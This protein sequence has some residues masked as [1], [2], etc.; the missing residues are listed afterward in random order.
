MQTD[1]IAGE[2]T[3]IWDPCDG[4]V[5]KSFVLTNHPSPDDATKQKLTAEL[6]VA[7][8]RFREIEGDIAP[9]KAAEI[10]AG[11]GFAEERQKLPTQ[12]LSGGWRARV[13]LARALFAEPDVGVDVCLRT[14]RIVFVLEDQGHGVS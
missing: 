3:T 13:A 14:N 9:H 7:Q 12:R 6:V 10:L 2:E 1:Q 5:G 11:L 8:E 4:R